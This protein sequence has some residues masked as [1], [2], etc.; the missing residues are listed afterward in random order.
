M[1]D[2]LYPGINTNICS[3]NTFF[4]FF[5]MWF[6]SNCTVNKKEIQQAVCS[7]VCTIQC[8]WVHYFLKGKRRKQQ[9]VRLTNHQCIIDVKGGTAAKPPQ[10]VYNSKEESLTRVKVKRISP[11]C[12]T[13][14]HIKSNGNLDIPEISWHFQCMLELSLGLQIRTEVQNPE[15]F[16]LQ[17]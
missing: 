6:L 5:D 15:I 8:H 4:F 12:S 2:L 1:E 13:S 7:Q 9:G 11:M 14:P 16:S 17:K 10:W 3:L